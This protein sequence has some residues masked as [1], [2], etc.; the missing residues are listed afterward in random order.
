M[1]RRAD[2]ESGIRHRTVGHDPV[3]GRDDIDIQI[4]R[5][6]EVV[7]I[8]VRGR[9]RPDSKEYLDGNRLVSPIDVRTRGFH[10]TVSAGLRVEE[11]QS[12]RSELEQLIAGEANTACLTSVEEWLSLTIQRCGDDVLECRGMVTDSPGVGTRMYFPIAGLT[13]SDLVAVVEQLGS[14]EAAYPLVGRPGG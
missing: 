4:G 3:V 14:V 10:A 13:V 7:H 12:F 11:L 8:R 6:R 9:E 2:A 5:L 1:T